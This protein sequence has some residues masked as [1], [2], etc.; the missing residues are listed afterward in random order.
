MFSFLQRKGKDL[1]RRG[2]EKSPANLKK[3]PLSN[4]PDTTGF[5]SALATCAISRDF[6]SDDNLK[7]ISINRLLRSNVNGGRKVSA[8]FISRD[9]APAENRMSSI[10]F[11]GDIR[12]R[13]AE[14]KHRM[15]YGAITA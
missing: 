11:T 9:L 4:G 15:E 13:Y 2:E 12:S 6:K 5:I 10:L 14:A 7:F 3:P 8:L 1:D